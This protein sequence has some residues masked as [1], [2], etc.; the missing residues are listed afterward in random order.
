MHA[1]VII[2]F[3]MK[4]CHELIALTCCHNPAVDSGKGACIAIHLINV[5]RTDEGH[6]NVLPNF[7]YVGMSEET[8]QLS[9]VGI[10]ANINIHS[11]YALTV[12]TLHTLCQ[13]D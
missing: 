7:V 11:G 2:Q 3:G 1:Y 5:W 8:A 9:S 12:F 4:S 13:K 6:R 10:A